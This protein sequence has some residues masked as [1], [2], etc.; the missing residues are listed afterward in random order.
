MT[1]SA[2]F[3]NIPLIRD[4]LIV[5]IVLI[6]VATLV[7]MRYSK[8]RDYMAALVYDALVARPCIMFRVVFT[9]SVLGTRS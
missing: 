6:K 7:E 8:I 4:D 9:G 5:I 2:F 3:R 1:H